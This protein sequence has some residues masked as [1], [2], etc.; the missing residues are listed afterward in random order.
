MMTDDRKRMTIV[1]HVETGKK[2]IFLGPGYGLAETSRPSLLWGNLI[3]AHTKDLHTMACIA[4]A[5]GVI[6]WVPTDQLRVVSV[7]GLDIQS[8]SGIDPFP[9]SLE[10]EAGE[11][12]PEKKLDESIQCARCDRTITTTVCPYCEGPT[13]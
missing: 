13:R 1:Q 9:L 12:I 5:E 11:Q 7:D 10:D 2:Y 8:I 3:P 4:D 6:G